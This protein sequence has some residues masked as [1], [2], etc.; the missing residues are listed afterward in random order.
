MNLYK[1]FQLFVKNGIMMKNV[2][3]YFMLSLRPI[4]DSVCCVTKIMYQNKGNE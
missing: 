4:R 1:G 3:I 2:E